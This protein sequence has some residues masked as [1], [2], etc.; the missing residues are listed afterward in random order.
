[1]TIAMLNSLVIKSYPFGLKDSTGC[2]GMG[3]LAL[4]ITI[5]KLTQIKHSC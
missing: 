3:Q 4:H 5:S 2:A 1:M